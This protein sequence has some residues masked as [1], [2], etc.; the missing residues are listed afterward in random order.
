MS[1]NKKQPD[2]PR[3]H[4]SPRD[5]ESDEVLSLPTTSRMRRRT[6][7]EQ[8]EKPQ[9]VSRRRGRERHITVRSELRA[10]PDLRKF[11]RAAIALAMAEAERGGEDHQRDQNDRNPAANEHVAT[12][13]METAD[14]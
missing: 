1:R 10:E 3:R 6:A 2:S 13:P 8:P 14:E 11:A 4:V 7:D 5:W 9:R 12:E